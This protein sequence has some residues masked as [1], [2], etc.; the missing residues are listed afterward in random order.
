MSASPTDECSHLSAFT[1][2]RLVTD[3]HTL[4][5]LH[6]IDSHSNRIYL[7]GCKGIVHFLDTVITKFSCYES[8]DIAVLFLYLGEH[9]I[10]SLNH[11]GWGYRF[12]TIGGIVWAVA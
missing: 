12:Q 7:L 2:T 8:V 6:L 1:Y 3:N 10:H 9:L 11:S 4:P 5:M